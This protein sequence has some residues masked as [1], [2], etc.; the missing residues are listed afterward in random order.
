MA[1]PRPATSDRS[2]VGV[3]LNHVF[4]VIDFSLGEIP[5]VS[6]ALPLYLQS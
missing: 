1:A 3:E 4:G 6:N 5:H 2:L